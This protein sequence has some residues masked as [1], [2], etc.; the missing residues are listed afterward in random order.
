MVLGLAWRTFGAIT[1][2]AAIYKIGR[3]LVSKRKMR[4]IVK[5]VR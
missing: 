4:K 3:S 2:A 5:A 1:T